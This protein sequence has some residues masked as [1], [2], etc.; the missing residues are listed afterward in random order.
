M[1]CALYDN[2][3]RSEVPKWRL[4]DKWDVGHAIYD[5]ADLDR[6]QWLYR[7][8]T[9]EDAFRMLRDRALWFSAPH[10]W[11]DPH[12]RWWCDQLF[13]DD[14]RL[15]TAYAYGLCWTQRWRDE[16]FWRLYACKCDDTSGST[17]PSRLLPAVRFRAKADTLFQWLHSSAKLEKECKAFMGLVRYC[18][19]SQLVNA[20]RNLRKA[21]ANYTASGAAKGLHMKR[22]A[23]EFE[24]E[25]RMLWIDRKPKSDGRAIPFDPIAMFDRVMIGPTKDP[26]RYAE[27]ESTLM[28]LGIPQSRIEPSSIWTVPST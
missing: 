3:D 17:A 10:K 6:A 18:P 7:Y 1:K 16:P 14:S 24:C 13:R 11:D 20:A 8:M 27:V 23:Y 15:A 12:E 9:A 19:V 26:A 4:A 22:R 2:D 21:A 5:H 25:V 28:S